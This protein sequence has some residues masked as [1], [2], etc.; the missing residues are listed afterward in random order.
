[1]FEKLYRTHKKRKWLKA[2]MKRQYDEMGELEKKIQ[3]QY[4]INN[5]KPSAVNNSYRMLKNTLNAIN[6]T[7][8]T[9]NSSS[10]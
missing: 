5:M 1:M 3:W 6:Q 7:E 8:N 10:R 2:H 9:E 4:M